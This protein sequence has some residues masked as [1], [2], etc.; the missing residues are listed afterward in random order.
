MIKQKLFNFKKNDNFESLVIYANG[1]SEVYL[2]MW[3]KYDDGDEF[4][5]ESYLVEFNDQDLAFIFVNNFTQ[6]DADLY[7]KSFIE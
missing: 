7:I 4:T 1:E 6:E 2:S 5:H 3:R